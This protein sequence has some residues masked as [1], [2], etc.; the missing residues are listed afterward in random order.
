MTLSV[1]QT[2]LHFHPKTEI[3]LGLVRMKPQLRDKGQDLI[4]A[5]LVWLS[6]DRGEKQT[7]KKDTNPHTHTHRQEKSDEMREMTPRKGKPKW[8][9]QSSE[10]EWESITTGEARH[11]QFWFPPSPTL[12]HL[13]PP[14]ITSISIGIGHRRFNAPPL[15]RRWNFNLRWGGQKK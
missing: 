9:L 3:G 11:L 14:V 8:A 5:P 6:T 4:S 1:S 13:A 12:P 7:K 10:K 15:L 2:P